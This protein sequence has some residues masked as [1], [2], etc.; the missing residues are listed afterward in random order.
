[1]FFLKL[2]VKKFKIFKTCFFSI[3]CKK[4]K[5]SKKNSWK[6]KIVKENKESI[7]NILGIFFK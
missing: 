5:F 7:E 4:F 3:I 6:E 2:F 1:M